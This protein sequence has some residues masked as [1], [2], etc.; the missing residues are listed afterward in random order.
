MVTKKRPGRPKSENPLVRIDVFVT[1]KHYD[2]L[3]EAA[4]AE[5]RTLS[6]YLRL[7]IE[8]SV[9]PSAA[10]SMNKKEVRR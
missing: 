6:A 9:I 4:A 7:Q 5:S 10:G 3:A 2:L 8:R 1:A